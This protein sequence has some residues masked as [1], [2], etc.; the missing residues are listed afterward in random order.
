MAVSLSYKY[1][2]I[3]VFLIRTA[4]QKL[5]AANDSWTFFGEGARPGVAASTIWKATL[6]VHILLLTAL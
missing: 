6:S 4:P 2:D 3:T 1:P 5:Q